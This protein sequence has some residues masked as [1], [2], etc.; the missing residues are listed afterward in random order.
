MTTVSVVDYGA[1]P[2]G[3]AD[4]TAAIAAACAATT[5]GDT[6]LFPVV[7]D[8]LGHTIGTYLV[9]P[10]QNWWIERKFVGEKA[11]NFH[12]RGPKIKARIAGTNLL[13]GTTV[14]VEVRGIDFDGDGKVTNAVRLDR[15][16]NAYLEYVSARNA[17]RGFLF[18]GCLA[19]GSRITADSCGRGIVLRGANG[20]SLRDIIATNCD[21]AG[22]VIEGLLS[23]L[24][25]L[26][27][28]CVVTTGTIDV[29]C[30]SVDEGQIILD[31]VDSAM[32]SGLYVEGDSNGLNVINGSHNCIVRD[33]R[34]LG[35]SPWRAVD[36]VR[37]H[38]CLFD[39][40]SANITFA[41][42]R[43]LSRVDGDYG[44]YEN[45][46]S[47]C[48]KL[49]SSDTGPWTLR[50]EDAVSGTAYT[51]SQRYTGGE[52]V[53][54]V[55]TVGHWRTWDRVGA[56]QC[57]AGGYPGTWASLDED[58]AGPVNVRLLDSLKQLRSDDPSRIVTIELL[59]GL[60]SSLEEA[61]S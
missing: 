56:Y 20:T 33:V 21:G 1:D 25:T 11:T 12:G 35:G 37:G 42:A 53:G 34:F 24:T 59:K 30:T 15:S 48:R 5:S 52:L 28:Q 38:G 7:P 22:L 23:G 47:H 45:T 46:F 39:G 9:D 50:F 29:N 41:S 26:S 13:N 10:D 51:A 14:F 43:I 55:P 44:S 6:I 16:H 61:T 36:V 49:S 3:Q 19:F 8:G 60:L 18:E 4:S 17:T 57:V 2:T 58:F 40:C 31:G 32:V 54:T 27:G